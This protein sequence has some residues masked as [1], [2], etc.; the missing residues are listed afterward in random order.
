MRTRGV[1]VRSLGCRVPLSSSGDTLTNN[2]SV[3]YTN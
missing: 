3:V 1:T 2:G